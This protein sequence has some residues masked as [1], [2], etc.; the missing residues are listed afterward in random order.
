MRQSVSPRRATLAWRDMSRLVTA[1]LVAA[2][3]AALAVPAAAQKA[4]PEEVTRSIR[5]WYDDDRIR[6]FEGETDLNG[7]GRPEIVVYVVG[8][9]VCGTG[10]CNLLVF[11]PTHAGYRLVADIGLTRPP[12]RAS[13]AVSAGWRHLVVHISG[14]GV[15]SAEVELVSDGRSYPGN[16]TIP[17]PRVRPAEL[18]GTE[19]L[20]ETFQ[21][22][23][24]GRPLATVAPA[25]APAAE[26]GPS[27]DGAGA[28][29]PFE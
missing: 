16:P 20:I 19:L 22:W 29:G 24:Q 2:S 23:T 5:E 17:G 3:W 8:L 10:G 25:P 6:T 14:G 11:S 27:F 26:P 15:A 7:D 12:I 18:A 21:S 4:L 13:S 1:G 9:P 28:T